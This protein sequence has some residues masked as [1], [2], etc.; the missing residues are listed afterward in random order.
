MKTLNFSQF[1]LI[2]FDCYGTLINWEEG[3]FD[4][5][6]PL[7][8]R[9]GKSIG[10]AKILELYG[11]FEA[12][13][14][15]GDYRPYRQ[16]HQAVTESFARYLDFAPTASEL[17]SLADSICQWP[18]FPDTQDALRKLKT[19]YKLAIISNIDDDLFDQTKPKLGVE[20]DYVITAQQAKAYKPSLTIFKLAAQK[21]GIAPSKWLH[22][23]QSIYH[24]V[25]P[26]QS[27]GCSSVWI[28]RISPRTNLGAVKAAAGTPDLELN[29]L[30][31][32]A[33][34]ALDDR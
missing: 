18:V 9:Y 6:T 30:H 21:F 22:V 16:V 24:D 29:D 4:S 33:K 27:M 5:L 1:E 17:S 2:S 13:F 14:E 26:A 28:N 31:S 20:F 10:D 25:L 12:Q 15:Q 11:D 34:L 19:R 3:I 7:F 32:L 23:G 8:H